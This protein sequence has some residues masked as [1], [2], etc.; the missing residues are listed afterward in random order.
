[1][2]RPQ[3]RPENSFSTGGQH[4]REFIQGGAAVAAALGLSLTHVR[5][6]QAARQ[7]AGRD[8]RPV[9]V[10]FIGV[11]SQGYGVDFKRALSIP[12]VKMVAVADIYEPNLQRALKD[13]PGAK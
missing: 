13:V 2:T 1:M 4:R 8:T 10:G 9:N 11:G 3:G 6:A 7:A 5:E 12:G